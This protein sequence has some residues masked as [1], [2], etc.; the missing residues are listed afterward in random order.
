MVDR[1]SDL[2][3][4]RLRFLIITLASMKVTTNS[5][6]GM[7]PRARRRESLIVFTIQKAHGDPL[8]IQASSIRRNK[9]GRNGTGQERKLMIF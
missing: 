3:F 5:T 1:E 4:R 8:V 6:K 2:F 7:S 9:T